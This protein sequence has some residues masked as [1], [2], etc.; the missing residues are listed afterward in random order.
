MEFFPEATHTDAAAL[1]RTYLQLALIHHPDKQNSEAD[2]P[3]ATA[4]FQRIQSAYEELH[5]RLHG[6]GEM[7]RVRTKSQFCLACELGDVRKVLRL[8][9]LQPA[10]LNRGDELKTMPL[11]AA[12]I[13][14]S[15]EVC[16]ILLA[17]RAA[18]HAENALGWTA[19]TWAGLHEQTAATK[20]LLHEGA[21]VQD[22]DLVL[23]AWTGKVATLKI[24]IEACGAE[25]VLNLRT[26]TKSNSILHVAANGLVYLKASAEA[27]LSCVRLLL[28][29][30]CNP[31]SSNAAGRCVLQQFFESMQADWAETLLDESAPHLQA[32]RWLCEGDQGTDPYAEG[33]NSEPSADEVALSLGM[34]RM[35][36]EMASARR[37]QRGEDSASACFSCCAFFFQNFPRSR[38]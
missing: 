20:L 12:A 26:D 30:K 4:E 25:R 5:K 34:H 31:N 16:Q 29:V 14:G 38:S 6:R 2:R 8:L 24:F 17:A 15:V 11:M 3:A 13:G 36:Q 22:T 9:E 27:H 23:L 33:P 1:R 32:V 18:L 21:V 10:S 37:R 28:D 7:T 35:R 19:L